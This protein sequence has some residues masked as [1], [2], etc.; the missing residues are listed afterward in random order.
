MSSVICLTYPP[1][2]LPNDEDPSR[3][4]QA[5]LVNNAASIGHLSYV[6]ELP[7]LAKLRSEMDLN[8]TSC[9]WLSSKFAAIFGARKGETSK[10]VTETARGDPAPDASNNVVVNV[11]SL[12]A[13]QPFETWAGYC[14]GKAGRDMFHR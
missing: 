10:D 5:V 14:S 3:Y 12:G 13:I 7:S 2:I 9:F 11:S 4:A 8:V 6:N 1:T